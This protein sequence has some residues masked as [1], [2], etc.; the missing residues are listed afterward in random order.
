V[1]WKRS[2]AKKSE[3]SVEVTYAS[4][5]QKEIRTLV[6][7]MIIGHALNHHTHPIYGKQVKECKNGRERKRSEA[8]ESEGKAEVISPL[9]H[10]SFAFGDDAGIFSSGR[11]VLIY[12]NRRYSFPART[13]VRALANSAGY[14]SCH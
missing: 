2:E 5:S 11:T 7:V 10:F 4:K 1:E 8:K 6:P 12:L 14:A 13:A 3:G 9:S